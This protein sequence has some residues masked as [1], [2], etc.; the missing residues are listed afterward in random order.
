MESGSERR[1]HYRARKSTP[2]NIRVAFER[3]AG[4]PKT[5]IV[6]TVMDVSE[7]GCRVKISGPLG[8]GS[9][10]YVDKAAIMSNGK[11][12]QWLARVAWCSVEGNGAYSAGLKLEVPSRGAAADASETQ[13]PISNLPDYYELLQLNSKADTD[14]IHRVYRILA[15]RFHPD[16]KESGDDQTFRR[17]IEG[18]KILS[19]PEQR[20]SYDVQLNLQ[21]QR[22]W[23][24]FDQSTAT[25]GLS[26]E[27]AKRTGMLLVMYTRRRNESTQ[28]AVTVHEMEDLL[29]CPKEHLEFGLWYLREKGF[30]VRSDNGKYAITAAG[31]EAA[32]IAEVPWA[33]KHRMIESGPEPEPAVP[34]A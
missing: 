15:Q 30:I 1:K 18:Y 27:K 29:G 19:D 17:L 25:D 21:N 9:M 2:Q 6:A 16:N 5:E 7:G 14:T 11:P 28:P 8:V 31:V 24:I 20:A 3:Q 4:A 26:S 32:E 33:T 22:R 34:R 13:K 10:V 12:E 23:K